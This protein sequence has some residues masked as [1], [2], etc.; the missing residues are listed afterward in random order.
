MKRIMKKEYSIGECNTI[1]IQY[2]CN[3]MEAFF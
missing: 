2:N 3:T 1:H